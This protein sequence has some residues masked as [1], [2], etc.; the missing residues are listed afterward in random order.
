MTSLQHLKEAGVNF[1]AVDFDLTLVDTHTEGRWPGTAPELLRHVRPEMRQLLRDALDAK[2]YVAIVTLS[3]QTT[4]IREV[5]RLLFPQDFQLII[6]RGNSGDWFYAGQG[7]LRGKQSH[8]ASAVEELSH[9]H[10]AQISRG[11]TLLIDDDAQNIN[12]ALANGVSALLFVPAD[13]SCVA[14]GIAALAQ[15]PA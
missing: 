1:L 7:S 4:L 9:A 5:M 14:R 10:A 15:S 12:D 11:S 8:I 2:L 13:P 6:I 3:P